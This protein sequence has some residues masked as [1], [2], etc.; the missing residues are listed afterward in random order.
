MKLYKESGIGRLKLNGVQFK[1]ILDNLRVWLEHAFEENEVKRVAWSIEDDR[2]PGL[3]G[4]FMAFFKCC[5][6]V[7]KGDAMDIVTNFHEAFFDLGSNATFIYLI[8]KSKHAN[9]ISDFR[10]ISFVGSV[11]KILSKT[12]YCRFKEALKDVISPNHSAFLEGT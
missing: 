2:A 6:D 10:S 3:D 8:L 4:F 12:L 9:R 5:W 1:R 11:Y 7:V